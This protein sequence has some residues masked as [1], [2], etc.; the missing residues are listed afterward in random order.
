M[1]SS[2]TGVELFQL[3]KKSILQFVLILQ[4]KKDGK[5]LY[6]NTTMNYYIFQLV[7]SPISYIIGTIV[8]VHDILNP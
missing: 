4:D 2:S 7:Q 3:L 1:N 5:L 6:V 8:V